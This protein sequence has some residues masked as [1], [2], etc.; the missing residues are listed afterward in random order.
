MQ[1]T[2][3]YT[4]ALAKLILLID[5]EYIAVRIAN[6]VT[7]DNCHFLCLEKFTMEGDTCPKIFM[8]DLE[9]T[10]VSDSLSEKGS[11]NLLLFGTCK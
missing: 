11:D 10:Y 5:F 4:C 3:V 7:S 9:F 6:K 1:Y 2:T 8:G